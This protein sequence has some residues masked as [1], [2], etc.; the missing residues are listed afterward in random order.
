[1]EKKKSWLKSVFAYAGGEKKK[2]A[3][4]VV[5]SIISVAAGLVPFYCAYKIICLFAAG[6]EAVADV[7]VWCAVAIAAY[8]VKILAFSLMSV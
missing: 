8:A 5:L 4:S 2:M 3:L 6:T 1:M 7:C